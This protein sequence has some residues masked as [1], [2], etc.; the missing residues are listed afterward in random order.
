[1]DKGRLVIVFLKDL[2][3]IFSGY[4]CACIH[5]CL[6]GLSHHRNSQLELVCTTWGFLELQMHLRQ[7]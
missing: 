4:A 5:V 7:C 6:C 3:F 1:M 2:V